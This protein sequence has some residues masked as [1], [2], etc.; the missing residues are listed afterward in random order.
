MVAYICTIVVEYSKGLVTKYS[1][2]A[3]GN[4]TCTE[5]PDGTKET[6]TYND[7]G[8][9]LTQNDTRSEEVLTAYSYSYNESGNIMSI[10]GT[11]SASGMDISSLPGAEMTYDAE[12]NRIAMETERYREEYVVDTVSSSLS[13]VLTV[14][15][16]SGTVAGTGNTTLCVYGNGLIYEQSGD[17][18]LYHHYNHLGSTTKLT[19]AKGEVEASF[20]YGAY[21]EL[22]SGDA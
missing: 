5:H 10:R 18:Y 4:L 16:K 21:G 13:R 20:T 1:Y 2:D 14:Y 15:G 12:N 22:L 3:R 8:F 6:R 19:D 9:L 11:E 7:V 17:I